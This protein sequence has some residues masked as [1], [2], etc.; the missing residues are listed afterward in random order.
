VLPSGPGAPVPPAPGSADPMA[1]SA[2]LL[3]PRERA[4]WAAQLRAEA[5]FAAVIE[6]GL[7][8]PGVLESE[9]S[10]EIHALARVSFGVRRHWHRRVVRS[11]PNSALTYYDAPPDRRLEVDDV[12]YLGFGPVFERWEADIGRTYVLGGDSRKQQLVVDIRNAFRLG[13]PLHEADPELTAGQ[14]YDY[15][16]GLT[17]APGWMFGAPTAGHIIDAFPHE[18]DPDSARRYS[19]RSGNPIPLH[20]PFDDGRS[21]HWIL[22]IHFVDRDRR[23]GGFL[24]ELLTIRG[25]R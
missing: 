18:R 13:Q 19:I 21:R 5:L 3:G 2:A 1:V 22:E 6:R 16:S 11:G 4:L 20:A 17:T 12:V 15:V 25:P 24:E 7:A 23:Y 8:R 14:L 10:E 9:L